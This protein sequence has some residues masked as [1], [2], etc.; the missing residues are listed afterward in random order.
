MGWSA[1]AVA[2][3][4]HRKKSIGC[5]SACA[6][7]NQPLLSHGLQ[8][9]HL[10]STLFAIRVMQPEQLRLIAKSDDQQLCVIVLRNLNH[11]VDSE[12]FDNIRNRVAMRDN[13][14]VAV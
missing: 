5:S 6:G 1:P 10:L 14:R 12:R 8:R 11:H 2:A 4:R 13:Q 7:Y 9:R 3:T